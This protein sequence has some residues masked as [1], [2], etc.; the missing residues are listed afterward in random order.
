MDNDRNQLTQQSVYE[1]NLISGIMW[2][3][4]E[5]VKSLLKYVN[6]S[7]DEN[8]ALWIAIK[9][10]Y[11]DM[12]KLLLTDPRVGFDLED[13]SAIELAAGIGRK[14]IVALLIAD[15][16]AR[17]YHLISAVK[18]AAV[19]GYAEIVKLLLADPRV[20]ES[21]FTVDFA[22]SMASRYGHTGVVQML[23]SRVDK[24]NINYEIKAAA[25]WNQ[26]GV[27]KLLLADPRADS[28]AINRAMY[29]TARHGHVDMIKLLMS[30]PRV[31]PR[32]DHAAAFIAG[33]DGGQDKVTSFFIK[34]GLVL[35]EDMREAMYVA[36]RGK[37]N[38]ILQMLLDHFGYYAN[39]QCYV[40]ALSLSRNMLTT[41]KNN[42][43]WRSHLWKYYSI[44]RR[45]VR[46]HL[47]IDL[48]HSLL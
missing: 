17:S 3:D 1:A 44:I 21:R 29:D 24:S 48:L 14:E 38:K 35:K 46:D 26:M 4:V 27:I 7:V 28:S 45:L 34:S 40:D 30:D 8:L 33:I 10:G 11:I 32:Y 25:R 12:V 13:G 16:R 18:A 6:P 22:L 23:L 47:V 5:S 41:R 36:T 20:N 9:R 2:N 15:H 43:S 37:N 39:V 31:D 19:Y 42:A